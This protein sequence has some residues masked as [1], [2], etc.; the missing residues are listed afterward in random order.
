M[1]ADSAVKQEKKK[2]EDIWTDTKMPIPGMNL[3]SGSPPAAAEVRGRHAAF[4]AD[5]S[6]VDS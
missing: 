2:K 6:L 4:E 5:P 3:A 1:Q